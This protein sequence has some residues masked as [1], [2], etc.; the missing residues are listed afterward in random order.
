MTKLQAVVL[1]NWKV[2][3]I[4]EKRIPGVRVQCNLV[5]RAGADTVLII[6]EYGRGKY[7]I[8]IIHTDWS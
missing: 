5:Y 1:Q 8:F 4:I 2:S 7:R 6:I 3:T